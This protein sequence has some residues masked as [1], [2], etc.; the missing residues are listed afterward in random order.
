MTCLRTALLGLIVLSSLLRVSALAA[1]QMRP[2]VVFVESVRGTLLAAENDGT[3]APILKHATF[4]DAR[5][6]FSLIDEPGTFATFVFSNG[7]S[8]HAG[9]GARFTLK[10]LVQ[11]PFEPSPEDRIVEPTPSRLK[12]E[13][14]HGRF[15]LVHRE[16][17]KRPFSAIEI[18]TPDGSFTADVR[19]LVIES[20]GPTTLQ[21]YVI[22]GNARYVPVGS[23]SGTT[24]LTGQRL[25]TDLDDPSGY[26]I[27]RYS[28][29]ELDA[30]A[31]PLLMAQRSARRVVFFTEGTGANWQPLPRVVLPAD[32][33][34]A[35]E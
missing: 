14:Q 2:G 5:V 34:D 16:R 32:F 31:A 23:A 20:N 4:R 29:Q 15:A 28:E 9:P 18:A 24:V 35:K 10:E 11:E 26:R 12:L 25:Q 22:T 3:P 6:R 13:L 8:L 27:E 19:H 17:G 21:A 1:A 33:F 30:I 7:M